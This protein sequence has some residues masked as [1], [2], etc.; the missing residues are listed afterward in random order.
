MRVFNVD[1]EKLLLLLLPS[2]IRRPV[3]LAFLKAAIAPIVREKALFDRVRRDNLYRLGITPQ[4]FSLEKM[5]NDRYDPY[6]RRIRIENGYLAKQEY[7]YRAAESK[8]VYLHRKTEGKRFWL[9]TDLENRSGGIDFFV[10]IPASQELP[11]AELDVLIDMYKLA[12]KK[13][14]IKLI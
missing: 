11:R 9:R 12:G 7:I 14:S 6:M 2:S 8:P 13:H 5:L 4:V 3:V 1:F 10:K